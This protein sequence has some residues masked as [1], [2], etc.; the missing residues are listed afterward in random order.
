MPNNTR[1]QLPRP[2]IVLISPHSSYRLGAYIKAAEKLNTPVIVVSQGK[3]SLVSAVASG[4]HVDFNHHDVHQQILSSLSEQNIGAVIATDDLTVE[5]ATRVSQ[6]LG[7]KHNDSAAI[8]YTRRKDLARQ[9]LANSPVKIPAFETHSLTR[10]LDNPTL[11]IA[12]PCVIKPLTLSG[13]RGV[14]RINNSQELLEA[15]TRLQDILKHAAVTDEERQSVLVE[16][17]I[18]GYEYAFEGLLD[19]GQLQ[20]LAL[21]DKPD[22]M[23]GPYFEETYYITPSRLNIQLQNKITRAVEQACKAYGLREGPVH[24]EMRIQNNQIW[25]MEMASRTIGGQCAQLLN[26]ATGLSL[27]EIVIQQAAGL[28][29][30]IVNTHNAAGVLMIPIKKRGLLRRVEGILAASKIN[31]IE[32]IE[33]SIQEGYELIPLPEGDSYLGF[34]FARAPTPERVEQALR[35]AY[36]ALT[37]ITSPLLHISHG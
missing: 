17:Y 31:Y 34:I 37:I 5:I 35:A 6:A 28:N 18:Q 15:C 19:N 13:S 26:Y 29:V 33:I 3:F 30:H 14:I 2:C 10:L 7:L 27:E 36:K 16:T 11:G 22:L 20:M 4:I 9:C 25:F 24:A 21:F 12:Y 32:D 1:A 8:R 23:E